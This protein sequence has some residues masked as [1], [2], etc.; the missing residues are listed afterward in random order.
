[1]SEEKFQY[2]VD[3][4]KFWEEKDIFAKVLKQNEGL[5]KFN[6]IE[7]PPFPTGDAHLG[8]LRNWAIKDSFLRFKRFNG[9]D[10]Y[11]RD[12]Y[13]VHGLPVENKVQK[14]LDLQTVDRLKEFGVNNFLKECKSY[15]SDIIG[16]M[17]SVRSRYGVWMDRNHYQTSHPEYISNSW[18]F[19]KKANEQGLLYK[20]YKTVAW[21]PHDET[22]LSDYEIKDSYTNLVDPSIYVKFPLA[23]EFKSTDYEES[24]VIWTTTP[25][26]LQSNMCIAM[27]PEYNYSKVLFSLN[28][29]KE[30]LV[31]ATNLIDSFVARM[32]KQNNI[33]FIEII[34][35]K[36]GIEF[37][38]TKYAHIYLNETP[39][40]AEFA[41]DSTHKYIHSIIMADY[42]TLGEGE[43]I[44]D[45]LDKKGY[46]HSI[47][48][49]S[50]KM[51]EKD[52]YD[53]I[54][55]EKNPK[56]T[57]LK[58]FFES[59]PNKYKLW[60]VEF[61][62]FLNKSDVESAQD[63]TGLVHIAPAHGFDDY[64]AARK[65]NVPVFCP[66]DSKGNMNEGKW[67]GL[68]FKEINPLAIEHLKSIGMLMYVEDKEHRY[69]CCWRCKTPI[70]YRAADQWWIRRSKVIPKLIRNNS[71]VTWTP[72]SAAVNFENLMSGAGDWAISRQR[73]WGIP[74]PI[75][76]DEEGNFEVIESKEELEEKTGRT[77][78]DLHIDDLSDVT[79]VGKAGLVMTRVPFTAD[80][81][82]DSGCASFAS[83]YGEGLNFDQIIERYYPMSWITEG[84]D[85]I[86]GWFSSLA[87]VGN[88]VTGKAPYNQVLF[89]GF[90]MA[91]DGVKM[92]KS[93]GNGIDGTTAIE[94]FGSDASRYYLLTKVSP[95]MK[96]NF[97]EDEL[98]QIF[99][100]FNTLENIFKFANSYLEEYE[101]R[102]T[103]A[104]DFTS[105]N[106]EDS[107]ILFRLN[108]TITDFTHYLEN[109]KT[110]LAFKTIEEFLVN[111]FSKTY[112]KLVKSRT[113]G[114]DENLLLIINEVLKKSLVMLSCAVPFKTE[115]L[116]QNSS[117]INKKESLFLESYP[118]VD[119]VLID[120]VVASEI[121][122]NF[123]LAQDVVASILNSRE[124]VKIGVRWPLGKVDIISVVDMSSK[125]SVF[126]S[127]IKKL[128]N[129]SKIGY[130]LGNI[131][132]DYDIK[133]NFVGLK[134]S[135]GNPSPAI[136]TINKNKASIVTGIKA[137][138]LTGTFDDLEI[139][140]SEHLIKENILPA[141]LV[142]SDFNGGN[143]VLHTAQDDVLLEEGYL[144]ELMRRVQSCRKDFGYDKSQSIML[145]FQGS[146]EY[147]IEL[148]T[149]WFSVIC[150]K[151]GSEEIVMGTFDNTQEFDIKGKKLV[152]SLK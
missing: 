49:F 30:V 104:M 115:E 148:A 76:E 14:K 81:W 124:K 107:W 150:R 98:K 40:Q 94:R 86:R 24:F 110:N 28:S 108:K 3:I 60:R 130:D 116:Y 85:Q 136:G 131:E 21:C 69:P 129:I 70:V 72:K 96:L 140:Y 53:Y 126:E 141:D 41:G 109:F 61:E 90:V 146:D 47:K 42:V 29:K 123:D 97:D 38:G 89:Q 56:P 152:V 77:F 5:T 43:D 27:N 73:F 54:L 45:K 102:H 23:A 83:H 113:E 92:S 46:K 134:K 71:G 25:W 95:E 147:F 84:E 51:S 19:F 6:F 4:Q 52:M 121:D 18:R 91:K 20:D 78:T 133:P 2:E 34:E 62:K 111:D 112:L 106:A 151:V 32:S 88:V 138:E 36:L 80:V 139:V 50:N 100:Y 22:T 145:S 114:R 137:G 68:Y 26:T 125:L 67:E 33:S 144:R 74:L 12:G 31:I 13:D 16:D 82:F 103:S 142:S 8:H 37:D 10:V 93:L 119:K 149:N 135:F 101:L 132:M 15:V 39:S 66:I 1:M 75:W 120:K 48:T 57:E 17:A 143:V 87:N 55:G 64:D 118:I 58:V 9:Y 11:A 65:Y 63:G 128:T 35:T 105:L 117:L 7:G 122:V 99:G 127:L 79:F 59:Y 44:F